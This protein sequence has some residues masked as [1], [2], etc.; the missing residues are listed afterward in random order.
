MRS[1]RSED[2]RRRML[3]Q[4][5][6]PRPNVLASLRAFGFIRTQQVASVRRTEQ[7]VN[8]LLLNWSHQNAPAGI[9]TLVITVRG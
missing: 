4:G 3:R 8:R 9:R 2:N 5:F 6:E 7:H 1:S